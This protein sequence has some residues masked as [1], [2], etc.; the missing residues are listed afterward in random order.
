MKIF[1]ILLLSIIALYGCTDQKK[2]KELAETEIESNI[3]SLLTNWHKAASEADF[4]KYFGAMDSISIFIG[5]DATENWTR[6]QFE[7]FCRPYFDKGEAWDFTTLERN[8]FVSNNKD[9]AWFD[10]I[11]N[12]WMGTCR[13]SGVLEKTDNEWKIKH[14]VLSVAIPNDNIKAV[15][16][17]KSKNDSVYLSK[18]NIKSLN[19]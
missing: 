13:G 8:I 4:E 6:K 7:E 10:E 12:T 18:Y 14:Y 5:T 19:N 1:K 3:D 17:A 15:I 9:V 16:E 2:G 11:L